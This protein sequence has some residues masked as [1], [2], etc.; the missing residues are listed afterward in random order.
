V[1]EKLISDG[2]ALLDLDADGV[3]HLRLN[4]PEASNGMNVPFLRAL[5]DAVMVAHGEPRLA[6]L[7][8]T[9][10]GPNFC[11]GGDVKTFASQGAAPPAA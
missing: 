4:R 2:L 3:G 11:A 10:E 9:G 1:T 5:Y 8:L 7:L 6:V